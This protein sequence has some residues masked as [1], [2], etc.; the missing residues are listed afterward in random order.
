MMEEIAAVELNKNTVMIMRGP[1]SMDPLAT[2]DPSPLNSILF[3][4]RTGIKTT[5]APLLFGVGE[6]FDISL[7]YQN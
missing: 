4:V 3:L 5:E 7:F 6:D 2:P 1:L